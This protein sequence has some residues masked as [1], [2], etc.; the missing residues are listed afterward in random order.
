MPPTLD[1][2]PRSLLTRAAAKLF[3]HSGAHIVGLHVEEADVHALRLARQTR[4]ADDRQQR[5]VVADADAA[6]EEQIDLPGAPDREQPAVLEEERPLL[7][8]QQVEAGQVDL[9]FVDFDLREVGVVGEVESRARRDAD[10][11]R[12]CPSRRSGRIR[13]RVELRKLRFAEPLTYGISLKSRGRRH[14]QPGEFA[15][16]RQPRQR[17]D[18]RDRRP[19]DRFALALDGAREVDAP[20]LRRRAVAQRP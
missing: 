8:E 2:L 4:A 6:A 1:R 16:R 17:V 15:R 14:V 5:A 7:R 13:F 18:A 11:W 12:R 19:V 3:A 9:L 20:R 10:S